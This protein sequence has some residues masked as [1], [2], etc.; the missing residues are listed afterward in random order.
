[1]L[2]LARERSLPVALMIGVRRLVNPP[3]RA[4]GDGLGIASVRA[5]ENLA[6]DNP[7][8]QFLA[9][10]IAREN[11]NELAV[12]SLKFPNLRVF[13]CWWFMN[14][15]GFIEEITRMRLELLGTGFIPQHSDCRV[16][17]QLLYKWDHSRAVIAGVLAEKY[18]LLLDAGYKLTEER[19][20]NDVDLLFRGNIEKWIRE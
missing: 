2:P 6:R 11:Q 14:N 7:D 19:I 17:D 5:V 4:A 15:P 8:L 10:V 9:T 13:G 18:G 3:L 12:A 1:M 16:V 20:K